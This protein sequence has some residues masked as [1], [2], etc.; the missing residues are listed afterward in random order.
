[1]NLRDTSELISLF[2]TVPTIF[3]A[4][5]VVVYWWRDAIVA[6]STPAWKRDASQWFVLGVFVGFAGSFLDN[7]YWGIAWT[8]EFIQHPSKDFWFSHGALPNIFVRQMAGIFA[9]F[10]HVKAAV[11]YSREKKMD[12]LNR[13]LLASL[14]LAVAYVATLLAIRAASLE[15]IVE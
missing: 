4:T 3:A 8:T 7:L 12:N 6:I 11:E 15:S 9:A 2:L 5:L 10:C 1:M 13:T 14:V